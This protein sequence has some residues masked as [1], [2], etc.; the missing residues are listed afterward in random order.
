MAKP[1]KNPD[2]DLNL[3]SFAG[4]PAGG[5]GSSP[6]D[7]ALAAF[8]S[9]LA[10]LD[11]PSSPAPAAK[12]AVDRPSFQQSTG[13]PVSGGGGPV[14][15]ALAAFS[16]TLAALSEPATPAGQ[17]ASDSDL[18]PFLR[19]SRGRQSAVPPAAPEPSAEAELPAFLRAS[20]ERARAAESAVA[21][22]A[23]SPE[24][25]L[26]AFLRVS[27]ERVQSTGPVPVEAPSSEAELPA[28]MRSSSRFRPAELPP[29]EPAAAPP[30]PEPPVVPVVEPHVSVRA[31]TPRG[32]KA[33]A[34]ESPT[35]PLMAVPETPV[36]P[37][38]EPP[39]SLF[40]PAAPAVS[41]PFESSMP[42]AEP[43]VAAPPVDFVNAAGVESFAPPVEANAARG[44][45][46]QWQFDGPVAQTEPPEVAAAPAE[47]AVPAEEEPDEVAAPIVV[48][49]PRGRKGRRARAEAEQSD[50]GVDLLPA[51]SVVEDSSVYAD[52]RAAAASKQPRRSLGSILIPLLATLLVVG[53]A[54]AIF[55]TI[56]NR[57]EMVTFTDMDGNKVVPD[58]QSVADPA[59]VQAADAKP[60]VGVRFKIPSVNLDVPLGEVSQVNGVI[61]PPGY[62]S[63]Y[64]V[65]NMGETLD[66]AAKG[67]V[68]TVTHSVRPPGRAPGNSIIDIPTTKVL[69]E[70]GAEIDVGDLKYT[71]V[72]SMVV[73]KTELSAQANLWANTPGMLVLITCM[74][75]N[76]N[77]GYVNGHSPDNT[78]IV[79]QLVT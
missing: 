61:N 17:P 7:D 28:F 37:V 60:D 54:T 4:A 19:T 27:R 53:G 24:A 46:R 25:E 1:T 73:A 13:A 12:P 26:P 72:S 50:S 43:A 11:E 15:D 45:G 48:K 51:G 59:Y 39:E 49:T 22:E 74:Q 65:R 68:Y 10:A 75:Y 55:L 3:P 33:S 30:S 5:A 21:P 56:R 44:A 64:R 62:T 36:V 76:S 58:D 77:A 38:V 69:V 18:P 9:A 32:R 16:S 63:V 14:D 8:S 71:V 52:P 79:G 78:V 20:R 29:E 41:L 40:Q 34:A 42:A 2:D 47:E 70:N 6:V 31:K 57:V 66:D 23:G 67:T 35:I